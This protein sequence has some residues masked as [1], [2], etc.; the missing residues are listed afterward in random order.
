MMNYLQKIIIG[1]CIVSKLSP[2]IRSIMDSCGITDDSIIGEE[3]IDLF[4]KAIICYCIGIAKRTSVDF[5]EPD[6]NE[7]A[8]FGAY[9]A[10]R[11]ILYY[12]GVLEARKILGTC[13]KWVDS[14]GDINV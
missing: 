6:E 1:D 3:A 7:S 9:E 5:C 8:S 14:T 10:A 11:D 4:S 13:P 2:R 12:F